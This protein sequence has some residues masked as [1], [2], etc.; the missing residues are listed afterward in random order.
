MKALN[1]FLP[2]TVI[3]VAS[4]SMSEP[5][6]VNKIPT[7]RGADIMRD[8]SLNKVG[9][10][11]NPT[12]FENKIIFIVIYHACYYSEHMFTTLRKRDYSIDFR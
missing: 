8:A 2:Q 12:S 11:C 3:P 5:K 4:F 1:W 6:R 9:F 10:Y 7:I